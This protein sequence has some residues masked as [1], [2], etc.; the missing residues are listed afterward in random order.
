MNLLVQLGGEKSGSG[1]M[2]EFSSITPWSIEIDN[3]Y[4]GNTLK[5][6]KNFSSFDQDP[7]FFTGY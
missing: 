3:D 6:E 7:N 5:E 4:Y 1:E 2:P